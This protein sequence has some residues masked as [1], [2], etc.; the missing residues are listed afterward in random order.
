[1]NPAAAVGVSTGNH[2]RS[3]N[4]ESGYHA[5][6]AAEGVSMT[7]QSQMLRSSSTDVGHHAAGLAAAEDISMANQLQMLCPNNIE[8]G[9]H[10]AGPAVAALDVRMANQHLAEWQRHWLLRLNNKESG[11][12]AVGLAA[13]EGVGMMN[14]MQML[15]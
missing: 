3:N 10:A 12:H 8:Y 14:Q 9:Y 6:V 4:T 5:P 13:A 2:C 15:R 1:M 7:N 11:C